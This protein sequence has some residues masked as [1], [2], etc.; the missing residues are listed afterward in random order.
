ML[1]KFILK[2]KNERDNMRKR[3][4][5]LY[6]KPI[7]NW[8][9]EHCYSILMI[10]LIEILAFLLNF[11]KKDI[12]FIF[13]SCNIHLSSLQENVFS[14]LVATGISG[15][16]TGGLFLIRNNSKCSKQ[17]K[18]KIYNRCVGL[19]KNIHIP[20]LF[21]RLIS[22]LVNLFYFYNREPIQQQQYIVD[23]ILN[24]LNTSTS[25]SKRLYWIQGSPY[26]GKTTTILNLLIDLISKMEYNKLF[27]KLDGKIMYFDL[28]KAD[29]NLENFQNDYE[30]EKFSN[31]LVILDNLHKLSGNVCLHILEKM[32]LQNHAFALIILLRH[33][34]EFLSENDKLNKLEKII[35]ENGIEYE[36]NPLKYHD[37]EFYQKQQFNIFYQKF[38]KLE[39]TDNIEIFIHL[40][41]LFVKRNFDT[42]NLI[43]EIQTFLNNDDDVN[44]KINFV[45]MV[46]IACSIFTGSFNCNFIIQC[47]SQNIEPNFKKTLRALTEIGFLTN[48]PSS[49]D[50]FYFHE[51]IAKFYFRITIKN[52]KQKYIQIFEKLSEKFIYKNNTVLSFLYFMLA[53]NVKEAKKYYEK[54]VINSNFINLYEEMMFLF[55]YEICNITSYYKEIGIVCDRCGKLKEAKKYFSLNLDYLVSLD[56][57]DKKNIVDAFYKLVQINHKVIDKYP[58]IKFLALNSSD[59]YEKNLS[60]YWEIHINM[61]RGIFQFE[62]MFNLASELLTNAEEITKKHPYD[63]LHLMRRLYFDLFRLYYLEGIF[64]PEKLKN[65]VGGK[66]KIFRI[67]KNSLEEFEAY[68]IKFAIGMMLAQDILFLLAFENVGLDLDKYNFLFEDYLNIEPD[69]TNNF[70]TIAEKTVL[71][72]LKSIELFD[73]IGDKTA[74][75]V[76]YHMY[77]IKLLLVENGDFS[78]CES[79]YQKYMS[80][81]T[82]GNVLEYQAYAETYKLKMSLIQLCTPEIIASYGCDQYDELK[83]V[84]RQKLEFVQKYEELATQG[85]GN[86]YA[87]LRLKLYSALFSFYIKEIELNIFKEKIKEINR[88]ANQKKYNRELKIVK[89]IENRDYQL[90]P[91]S[92]RIIFTYYPIVPQ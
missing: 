86:Q 81:A 15:G 14:T 27:E 2:V 80:F 21:K 12:I 62:K 29:I 26:S 47:F 76:E 22:Y 39:E 73:K 63:G 48:Y 70:K 5:V 32:V 84:I 53:Q 43:P 7:L 24:S 33:P 68:Y 52:N 10:I 64:Q 45:L 13:K 92:I 58:E 35:L 38:L 71:I 34:K 16:I 19:Y 23:E 90:S 82:K 74:I 37:F 28:G 54:A 49:A 57:L 66:S 79:F 20:K 83:N 18:R 75:F 44:C 69:Q 85:F 89:Y 59:L 61:H 3:N 42:Y 77:N 31:C 50:D 17:I 30:I 51:R 11:F 8:I 88:I 72:Y 91:E 6:F 41:M 67:L 78:E 56:S 1:Y 55:K 87:Q 60:N 40:Y 9:L 4:K 46:I 65:F 36:L 25:N